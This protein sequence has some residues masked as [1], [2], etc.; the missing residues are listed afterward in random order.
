M[1]WHGLGHCCRR[2]TPSQGWLCRGAERGWQHQRGA[3]HSKH[4]VGKLIGKG[5]TTIQQLQATTS[6]SIQIDQE[7]NEFADAK[8]VTVRGSAE[9]VASAKAQIKQVLEEAVQPGE[10]E[11]EERVNCPSTLVGR[12]IGRGGETIRSLQG[13]SGAHILVDQNYPEGA[14]SRVVVIKGRPDSV[15]R[16]TAMVKELISGE[17]G[18]ASQIIAKHGVGSTVTL[19]CPRGIVGRVI[20]KGGETIKGLQRKYHVSIQIDQGGDPMNVTITGPKHTSEACRQE[21]MALISD[22]MGPPFGDMGECPASCV[23][24]T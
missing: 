9:N 21:V 10:G 18:T 20:G 15:Q 24:V 8:K 1:R 13:G 11:V 5:G 6:T 23:C 7:G 16:A 14:D 12:I 19:Q 17:P 4:L 2:S 22:P 3:G